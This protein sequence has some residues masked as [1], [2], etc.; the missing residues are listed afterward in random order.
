MGV[1]R[2]H[3][4][5]PAGSIGAGLYVHGPYFLFFGPNTV[6]RGIA[7]VPLLPFIP[8]SASGVGPIYLQGVI[9]N[10][11]FMKLTNSQSVYP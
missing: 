5:A 3:A 2:A 6:S 7:V 9:G 10:A 11:S 4:P 8:A 1:A